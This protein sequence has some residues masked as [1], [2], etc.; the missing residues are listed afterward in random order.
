MLGCSP[1]SSSSAPC[2]QT[3][4]SAWPRPRSPRALR[5]GDVLFEEG[6]PGDELFVVESG[7]IAIANKSF[8]GRESVVAL[9]ERGRPVR[10]DEPVRRA[11][12]L[13]RGAGARAVDGASPSRSSRARAV[14][15]AARAAVERSSSCSPAASAPSTRRSPTPSSS[16][17]PGA[18]PSACSS[19]PAT[20]TSS[21]CPITQE[22]LA[23]LV[24]ASRE[25]VNKAIAVVRAARLDRAD[26]TAATDHATASSSSAARSSRRQASRKLD[27][28]GATRRRR[29]R[30]GGRARSGSCTKPCSAPS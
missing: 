20:A 19:S 13:G 21:S 5:R 27:R 15:R 26:A 24:G 30:R 10:R 25:R 22:E 1:R 4:S 29:R 28:R 14:R 6:D 12:P 9:M 2:P 23:G 8:D 7:R 11:G 17:S 18:P 3:P 16:T